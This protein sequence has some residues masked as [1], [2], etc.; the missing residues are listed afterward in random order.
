MVSMVPLRPDAPNSP[1]YPTLEHTAPGK[2]HGGWLVVA[3]AI[4]D[5]KS[6][7]DLDE[8]KAVVPLLARILQPDGDSE[9]SSDLQQVLD[10]LKHWRRV[11]A[12]A[13]SDAIPVVESE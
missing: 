3:A 7:F 2:G 13:V 11:K 9:A 10:R 12:P 1:R 6:D 4:N 5:M 8:M